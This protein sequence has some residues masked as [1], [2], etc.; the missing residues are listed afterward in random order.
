MVTVHPASECRQRV[1][2]NCQIWP[3]WLKVLSL[4]TLRSV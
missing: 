3:S 1:W 2:S 4:A